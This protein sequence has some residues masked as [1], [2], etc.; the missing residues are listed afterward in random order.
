MNKNNKTSEIDRLI[1]DLLDSFIRTAGYGVWELI[2]HPFWLLSLSAII[3]LSSKI[4]SPFVAKQYIPKMIP[5][6]FH[7]SITIVLLMIPVL[8][9][10]GV[11]A[12]YYVDKF[13]RIFMQTGLSNSAGEYPIFFK[14]VQLDEFRSR[15]YFYSKGIGLSEFVAKGE[16]I[17]SN[18]HMAIESIKEGKNKGIVLITFSTQ[19]FPEKVSYETLRS[20]KVLPPES[21]YLGQSTDGIY[22]QEVA[23]LPHMLIA[24]TT[25]SGKSV[26]FK[27]ALLG[28]LESS[29]HLQMYLIDLKGGLEMID[30]IA[31]PNVKVIKSI[32]QAVNLLRYVELE[33]KGRF[34]YLE[35]SGRKQIIPVRDKKDRIIVAVDEA[36]VLYMNR[37][38]YDPDNEAAIEARRLAD[39]ISK[40]SRAASIHLLLATQKLDRQVIPTSV[41]ENIS[42]RMAF[43]ANSLQGSLIVLGSKE[44]M[45]LPD[46]PGRGIWSYGTKKIVMQSPFVDEKIIKKRCEKIAEM[47]KQGERSLFEPMITD[48]AKNKTK[49][50]TISILEEIKGNTDELF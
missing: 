39:S 26:F 9:F 27:Q 43:R 2:K 35:S 29:P 22:T 17:E 32:D 50:S 21:M 40:L 30:F 10:I 14:K 41:S 3:F 48:V 8:L 36:S 11:M 12:R 23:D 13:Q 46:I 4:L 1:T 33:M 18:F 37:D 16:R 28:L 15:F 47:F 31:A 7:L 42:G 44:A 20:Q 45:E 19:H 5:L 34:K 24:G 38:K 49:L 6:N 25:G